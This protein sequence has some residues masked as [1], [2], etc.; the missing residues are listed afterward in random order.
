MGFALGYATRD[1]TAGIA[2]PKRKRH[3]RSEI[4]PFEDWD[5]VRAVADELAIE[6]DLDEAC[7]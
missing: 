2:N 6:L 3:E 4:H 5:Q 1:A 7:G